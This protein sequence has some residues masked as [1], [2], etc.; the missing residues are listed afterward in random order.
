MSAFEWR[1]WAE[2]RRRHGFALQEGRDLLGK[3]AWM[4]ADAHRKPDSGRAELGDYLISVR[5]AAVEA[6]SRGLSW[7][8]IKTMKALG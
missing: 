4:Y 1:C 6:D 2:Y 5:A 7:D 3:L 8:E